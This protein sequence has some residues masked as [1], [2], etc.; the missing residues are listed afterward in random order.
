MVYSNNKHSLQHQM[1][2]HIILVKPT[3]IINIGHSFK[4]SQKRCYNN[5]CKSVS[6]ALCTKI[7]CTQNAH[8]HT[9]Y[10]QYTA[11]MQ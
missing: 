11:I 10:L 2:R 3:C 4:E 9:V 8:T 6:T 7:A 1:T 5:S